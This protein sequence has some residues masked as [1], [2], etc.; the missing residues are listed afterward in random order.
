MNFSIIDGFFHDLNKVKKS[1][2]GYQNFSELICMNIG[3]K[4]LI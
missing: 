2:N 3:Y 4:I 1:L